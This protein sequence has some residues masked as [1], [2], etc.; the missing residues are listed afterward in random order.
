M[1]P[2]GPV[3]LFAFCLASLS[4]L[5]CFPSPRGLSC[6][7]PWSSSYSGL[8]V[9][10]SGYL[11]AAVTAQLPCFRAGSVVVLCHPSV[12]C[13]MAAKAYCPLWGFHPLHHVAGDVREP[14]VATL[15]YSSY[16]DPVPILDSAKLHYCYSNANGA[17]FSAPVLLCHPGTPL[18]FGCCLVWLSGCALAWSP[19]AC[20]RLWWTLLPSSACLPSPVLTQERTN[21]A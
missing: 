12:I 6:L 2:A 5:G 1:G 17:V 14:S 19:F 8:L 21:G 16:D 20:L 15:R 10:P 9:P 13:L 4:V 7:V 11:V 18:L 3:L